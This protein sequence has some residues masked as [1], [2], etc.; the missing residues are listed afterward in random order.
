MG[1]FLIKDGQGVEKY[2][3]AV[4]SGTLFDPYITGSKLMDNE[5]NEV[6]I[7]KYGELKV[8]QGYVQI[9]KKFNRPI[10]TN[11]YK[12]SG[13]VSTQYN[14]TLLKIGG[15]IGTHYVQTIDTLRCGAAQ[16]VEIY[17][18]NSWSRSTVNNERA[19]IG[20]FDDEDGVYLGYKDSN[21]IVGYRNIDISVTDT[22]Q[23]VD[24]SDYDLT[25]FHTFRIKFGYLGT[26]NI[27]FEIFDGYRWQI[28]HTFVTSASLSLRTHIGSTILPFKSEV[29]D[30]DG[31]LINFSGSWNAQ[32]Y[33]TELESD[34]LI[35]NTQGSKIL[36]VAQDTE[37]VFVAFKVVSSLGGYTNKIKSKLKNITFA[38]TSEGLYRFNIYKYNS[39]SIVTGTFSDVFSNESVLQKNDTV[40]TKPSGG[41][42]VSSIIVGVPSSG[43]GIGEKNMDLTEF[44]LFC[45]KDSEY[46]ITKECVY[47][48]GGTI[49]H[50][51]YDV[52][53]IDLI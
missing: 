44:G 33:G 18:S 50:T 19:L 30:L 25:K 1:N 14:K 17:F 47:D 23:V 51:I 46:L 48:A 16:T 31:T 45:D 7:G 27:T 5:K 9:S 12:Y 22:I 13:T 38:T 37:S 26:T 11:E 36:D 21:F 6:G 43:T 15:A 28:L 39:G 34:K 40:T 35:F 41:I 20:L 3:D 24:V 52:T 49:H 32:T 42:L 29:V 8:A 2:I 53:Y 4:G 10:N